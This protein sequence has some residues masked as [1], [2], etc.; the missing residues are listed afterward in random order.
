MSATRDSSHA[1]D[2]EE[3]LTGK[4]VVV[5]GGTGNVGEGIVRAFL[6]AGATAVV[7]G[8]TPQRLDDLADLVGRE[9]R[10]RLVGFAAP[11]GTFDEA[12]ALAERVLADH[13]R[14]DHV[15]A[16]IG[17]WWGGET[18]WKT[19]HEVYQRYFIDIVTSHL[20]VARAF[21][22]RMEEEGSY[23]L[24]TGFSAADPYPK[25]GVISMQGSALVM[26]R[27]VFSA[28]LRGSPRLND[29]LLGPIITRGRPKG[30]PSW[31]TADQVGEAAVA[32]ALSGAIRDR[33]V[34]IQDQ[35]QLEAI[36]RET[37]G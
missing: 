11:Y 8:R 16:S 35:T 27:R 37:R 2:G 15:V 30:N 24:I 29:L 32:V 9:L 33:T 31:L 25:A 4:V 13:G 22:P 36:R 6:S 21:V 10:A 19:S 5:A 23:T 14:I 26:M 28:E 7:P 17:G 12:N 18:I 20:G 1:R 3:P 34:Q